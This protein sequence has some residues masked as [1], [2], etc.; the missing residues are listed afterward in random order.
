MPPMSSG[1]PSHFCTS[2]TTSVCCS[3]S[4][5]RSRP[6]ISAWRTSKHPVRHRPHQRTR[7]LGQRL[8]PQCRSARPAVTYRPHPA[9][10]RRPALAADR[11][12]GLRRTV[13]PGRPLHPR[14]GEDRGPP[15]LSLHVLRGPG[16]DAPL[17]RLLGLT[18]GGQG[19]VACTTCTPGSSPSPPN[20][21][22][23][24]PTC[25]RSSGRTHCAPNSSASSTCSR[26]RTHIWTTAGTSTPSRRSG[27]RAT[28]RTSAACCCSR[29]T[30]GSTRTPLSRPAT[31][32]PRPAP[33]R[34]STRAPATRNPPW[35]TEKA[36]GP[37]TT[38]AGSE[39]N[40][41]H[42]DDTALYGLAA[43]ENLALLGDRMPA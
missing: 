42:T 15:G 30:R 23:A 21:S 41:V 17:V 22:S 32:S 4:I 9:G 28:E 31:R 27:P 2:T 43:I 40:W 36:S 19:A 24:N 16:R 33:G 13:P 38:V 10:A 26:S 20:P 35:K 5:P 25:P 1:T 34:S 7:L 14:E 29:A 8:H 39:A 18:R 3:T 11:R 6:E 12:E 37:V